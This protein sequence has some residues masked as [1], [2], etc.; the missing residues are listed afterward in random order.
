MNFE[1]NLPFD[2]TSDSHDFLRMC[3]DRLARL[4]WSGCA[5]TVNITSMKKAPAPPDPIPL[6]SVA[7]AATERNYGLHVLNDYP[8]FPQFT[9]LNLV[10]S[11][12]KEV[13]QLSRHIPVLGYDLISVTPLSDDV[14]KLVCSTIDVDII[15]I[16]TSKFQPRSSWKELKS[17]VNR[18]I[19]IELLYSNLLGS[20]QDQKMLIAS[21]DSVNYATK[22]K[23]SK[24]RI[25]LFSSGKDDPD[26]LRSPS[27]VRNF[28]RLLEIKKF[29]KL[30][31]YFTKC[32]IA[33]GL[34]RKSTAGIVRK[35]R[36]IP[37]NEDKVESSD[38]D[39]D[40]VIKDAPV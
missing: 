25:M 28:A 2:Q 14:F 6:S 27:D 37:T 35:T 17:A 4:G 16:D 29:E 36:E 22:G 13:H 40:I 38:D 3:I 23:K 30:T 8:I 12:V 31:S 20:D 34:A 9:R 1:L 33:N 15:S 21:C 39:F 5:L 11:D 19:A 24:D 10:T 32:V 26:L 18:K 7:K